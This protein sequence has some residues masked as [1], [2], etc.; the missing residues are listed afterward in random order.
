[1]SLGTAAMLAHQAGVLDETDGL[2]AGLTLGG[3]HHGDEFLE[4]RGLALETR[5]RGIGDVV[6]DHVHRPVRGELMRKTNKK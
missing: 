2:Q 4:F 1:M 3:P 5:R 6:R